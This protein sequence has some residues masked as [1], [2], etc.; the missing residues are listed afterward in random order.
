MTSRANSY[1]WLFLLLNNERP[2][3][4]PCRKTLCMAQSKCWFPG[5]ATLEPFWDVYRPNGVVVGRSDFQLIV[6]IHG[7]TKKDPV[8]HSDI[9]LP[10]KCWTSYLNVFS[11]KTASGHDQ[12]VALMFVAKLIGTND[13]MSLLTWIIGGSAM[14]D[15]GEHF[16]AVL[17][18]MGQYGTIQKVLQSGGINI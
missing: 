1:H 8:S 14:V 6:H 18:F 15:E 5:F 9:R 7:Q 17:S 3:S 2:N 11:S 13:F 16:N 12:K 10:R 4:S